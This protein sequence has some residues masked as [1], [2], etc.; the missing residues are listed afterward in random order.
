[1]RLA[2]KRRLEA[3][4]D[5][6]RRLRLLKGNKPRLVF[7]RTNKYII[8]QYIVSESAKDKAVKGIS[9]L[10]LI[11]YG[12]PKEMEGSLKSISAS[13]LTGYLMGKII[14]KEK[15]ETPVLDF[16]ML[17]MIH[18]T[19]SFA[20]L[21]GVI[22]SGVKIPCQK[23]AFPEKERIVGKNLKKDFSKEFEKIKSN[24]DKK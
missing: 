22:D 2:K 9:S 14:Q 16:G 19:K 3:K 1:M 20:F 10:E 7:R 8:T 12:W 11:K 23:E 15:L 4:T 5:Y 13:Y 24:I 6:G 17:R 18:K 21:N